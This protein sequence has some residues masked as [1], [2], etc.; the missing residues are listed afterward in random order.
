MTHQ[1]RITL[2]PT[3]NPDARI[4]ELRREIDRVN[5]QLLNALERRGQLVLRLM[6]LKRELGS[7]AFDPAREQEML[8]RLAGL[9]CGPF[10]ATEIQRIFHVIIA[11]SRDLARDATEHRGT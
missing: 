10:S 3:T 5:L 7:P 9:T 8:D 2:N 4:A 11:A 1:A 6:A